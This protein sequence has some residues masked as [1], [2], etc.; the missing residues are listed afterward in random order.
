MKGLIWNC[1]GVSKKGMSSFVKDFLISQQIDFIGLQE[2]IRKNY[3]DK[4]FR[5]IDHGKVYAWNWIPASGH[6]R[7]ILCGINM[8]KFDIISVE[9]GTFSIAATVLYKK[10][11]KKLKLVTVYGPAHD[12]KKDLF[13]TELSQVCTSHNYPMMVGGDFN[14]LRFSSEKNKNFRVNKFSDMFNLII[15]SHELRDIHINGGTFTW[16]NN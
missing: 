13:L 10:L 5:K 4:F 1:R 3:T 6:S 9:T 11:N 15:N 12:D 14:I 16:S 8:D 7:G 2:T